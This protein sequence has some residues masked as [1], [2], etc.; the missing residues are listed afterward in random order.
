LIGTT[1][2]QLSKGKGVVVMWIFGIV[3]LLVGGGLYFGGTLKKKKLDALQSTESASVKFLQ[4]LAADMGESVGAGSFTYKA[5][6]KGKV[7]CDDPLTS[8]LGQTACVHYD[9]KVERRYEE[10]YYEQNSQGERERRTRTGSETVSGNKRSA[11]FYLDDGDGKIKVNPE[12]AEIVCEKVVSRY[13]PAQSMS[14][15]SFRLG[16]FR[17]DLSTPFSSGDRKTLGYNFEEKAI[18]VGAEV[19]VL[20]EV[21]DRHG[22]LCIQRPTEKKDKFIIS[23]KGQEALVRGLESEIKGMTIGGIA[24]GVIGVILIIVGLIS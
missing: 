8:E 6:T 4:T 12:G 19:F 22:E 15:S 11:P 23:T 5:T 2:N 13:E 3:L 10:T 9:A 24:C 20:G 18:P 17:L 21:T 1:T 14:G 7:V 16:A